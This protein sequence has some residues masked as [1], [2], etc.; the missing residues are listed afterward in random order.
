MLAGIITD[1]GSP[2]GAVEFGGRGEF[3]GVMT[4]AFR[5]PRVEGTFTGE[6]LRAFD[7]LWGDGTAQIVVENSYVNVRGRRR[8]A[9]RLGDP[10]RRPASRSAIRATMAARRSTRAFRVARRDL[11]SL[12][13]A[14]GID[15]YPVSGLLSGD[16]HL[17]GEYER[18][19]GFGAMTIDDGV[20][21]GEPF[22]QATASLPVRRHRRAARQPRARQRH[23]RD[24]RRGVRRL[25]LAPTRSTPTAAA[26][27]WSDCRSCVSAT[28]RCR[29][30]ADFTAQRQRHVRRAAQRR[31]VPR[32][33]SV[34]RRGRRRTGHRDAGASRQRAERRNRRG[35]A[36]PRGD[37]HRPHR[38]DAAVATPS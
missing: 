14:F 10:R 33:R 11:D 2:T 5:S 17:T 8:A 16:F 22:Q 31:P 1:F 13:H 18:P 15:D 35:V 27:R 38:A 37:R 19:I 20:A 23:R 7:T 29:A 6:D 21:Y 36:A 9:R 26:F 4:G 25:G 3:D 24:D 34:R 12:R 28:R 32:Q 30:L